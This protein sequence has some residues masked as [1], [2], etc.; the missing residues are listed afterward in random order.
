MRQSKFRTKTP[1]LKEIYKLV[2][3]I[4]GEIDTVSELK[5]YCNDHALIKV[6]NELDVFLT[7]LEKQDVNLKK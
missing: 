7:D 1:D 5:G 6:S 2:F 4:K 3:Q